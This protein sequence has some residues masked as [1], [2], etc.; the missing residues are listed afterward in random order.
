MSMY[1]THPLGGTGSMHHGYLQGVRRLTGEL[2]DEFI[3][4]GI[5]IR[6]LRGRGIRDP[7]IAA[8]AML[9]PDIAATGLGAACPQEGLAV[10]AGEV[11]GSDSGSAV[12]YGEA[13]VCPARDSSSG[14]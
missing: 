11:I 12:Q 3:S 9:D 10:V 13:F 5:R 8:A 6:G 1:I 14:C 2:T 4:V 7:D